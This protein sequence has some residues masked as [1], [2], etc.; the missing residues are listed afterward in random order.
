MFRK[1]NVPI[2][3]IVENMAWFEC[4]HGVSYPIFGQ[5]GGA[6]EAARL[7]VP[8]L[9]QIPSTLRPGNGPTGGADCVA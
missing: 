3:G 4:D 5:G 2:S 7:G 6:T 8:L 9:G 1:V